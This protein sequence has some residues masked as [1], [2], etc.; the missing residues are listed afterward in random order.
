M[1]NNRQQE[2]VSRS[3]RLTPEGWVF[4]IILGFV[5]FGSVLRNV[6]LLIVLSGMMFAAI[7][8]N[9]RSAVIR[10]RSISATRALPQRI[11]AQNLTNVVWRC[12]NSHHS[13][14]AYSV[15]IEDKIDI[16]DPN[17]EALTDKTK[18]GLIA[19]IRQEFSDS[20]NR[21]RRVGTHQVRVNFRSIPAASTQSSVYQMWFGRRGRYV[22]GGGEISTTFPFG[23]IEIRI[24]M[25]QS[26]SVFVAPAIGTLSPTWDQRTNAALTGADASSRKRGTS[27]D[28][29]FALRK[30]KSGDGRKQIHWR[31]TA[32]TGMPMVKQFDQPSDLDSAI[33]IDLFQDDLVTSDT[34]ETL[35]SFAATAAVELTSRVAGKVSFSVCGKQTDAFGQIGKPETQIKLLRSLAVADSCS[36]PDIFSGIKTAGQSVATGTPIFVVSTRAEPVWLRQ[37]PSDDSRAFDQEENELFR[38]LAFPN[39]AVGRLTEQVR[40]LHIDT[41]E[42]RGLFEPASARDD[43]QFEN[44][45]QRWAS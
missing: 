25:N 26:S 1:T 41:E 18:P 30:W 39:S 15:N 38:A 8:L 44:F 21:L 34:V 42:F 19:R 4:L 35:L 11:F 14:P 32:K 40:W 24:R 29:F 23:L 45:R 43:V 20:V 3:L 10:M 17:L 2:S 7:I 16:D 12:S 13:H 22:A 36:D 33:V 31:S 37:L 5:S 27:D 9:W 6:N 28:Q